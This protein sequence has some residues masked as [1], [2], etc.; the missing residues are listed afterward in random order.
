M[1][2][3]CCPAPPEPRASY[4]LGSRPECNVVVGT[5]RF[6]PVSAVPCRVKTAPLLRAS[7]LSR[8]HRPA[9][10]AGIG[11]GA[12][13][14]PGSAT[15][16]PNSVYHHSRRAGP[17]YIRRPAGGATAW[18]ALPVPMG[19]GQGEC[20]GAGRGQAG[21]DRQPPRRHG[22]D[23][24][25]HGRSA[26]GR[27]TTRSP[28]S[29]TASFASSTIWATTPRS[30]RLPGFLRPR[31]KQISGDRGLINYLMRHR[32]TSPFEM[33]ELKLHVKLPIFVARQWIRHRTANVNEYSAA[34]RCSIA[35]STS[36]TRIS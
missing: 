4:F 14:R 36:P 34:I 17:S 33:C 6:G 22:A 10:Q 19:Q 23:A 27:S 1:G 26:R 9:E 20:D 21:R 5:C 16:I 31:T 12:G 18:T 28:S 15:P 13:L 3:F 35:S 29:I 11:G 25:G 7:I 24:P 2:G 30:C 8:P 32:H